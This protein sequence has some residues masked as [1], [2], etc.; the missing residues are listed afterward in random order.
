MGYMKNKGM[1]MMKNYVSFS[2]FV[3]NMR[4]NF[5]GSFLKHFFNHHKQKIAIH[6]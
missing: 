6:I 2:C 3:I 5:D 4:W 1:T